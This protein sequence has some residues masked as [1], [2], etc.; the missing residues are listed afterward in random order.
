MII[1][2]DGTWEVGADESVIPSGATV[3]SDDSPAAQ[4][5]REYDRVKLIPSENSSEEVEVSPIK[6]EQAE[7]FAKLEAL[8]LQAVRP[9][10]AIVAG[11]AT[12][13]DRQKLSEIEAEVKKLSRDFQDLNIRLERAKEDKNNAEIKSF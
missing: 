6:N 8:D 1:Y 11:T 3:L 7:I 5:I 10:R 13:T 2:S 12:E 9:L 4:K